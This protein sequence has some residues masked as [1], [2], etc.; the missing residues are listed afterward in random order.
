MIMVSYP[1]VIMFKSCNILSV[2]LVGV[3]CSRV[4]KKELKLTGNKL[5]S[6]VLVTIGI[7]AF[8]VFD[9]EAKVGD[10][11]KVEFIGL[12]FLVVSLL[13]DGFLPDFQAEIKEKFKP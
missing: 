8:K 13:A 11:K 6:A 2:I 1:I 3:C 7:I 9:P 12:I 10:A 5:I 4:K